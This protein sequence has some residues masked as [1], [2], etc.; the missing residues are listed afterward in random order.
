MKREQTEGLAST[1]DNNR[2][3]LVQVNTYHKIPQEPGTKSNACIQGK[4]HHG[5]QIRLEL[6]LLLVKMMKS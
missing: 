5:E 1:H 6:Y 4:P 3:V 2:D